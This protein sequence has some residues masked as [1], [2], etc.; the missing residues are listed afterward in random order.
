MARPEVHALALACLKQDT[1]MLAALLSA[2]EAVDQRLCSPG[3]QSVGGD[4]RVQRR[5]E[6]RLYP[7]WTA[8]LMCCHWGY[9]DC[10]R[11]LLRFNANVEIALPDARGT[12]DTAPLHH[13][14]LENNVEC[15]TL[16]LDAGARINRGNVHNST[17]LFLA[18]GLNNIECVRLLLHRDADV[19]QKRN[20]STT[21]LAFAIHF[22]NLDV[23]KLLVA[24]GAPLM[25][26][27]QEKGALSY[28]L[29]RLM[30]GQPGS[31]AVQS[32]LQDLNARLPPEV[33]WK[34][35][36]PL[37]FAHELDSLG[38]PLLTAE[39]VHR[40]L[41]SGAWKVPL[42][43]NELSV[44]PSASTSDHALL[45]A[46]AAD[47]W[48]TANHEL[49]PARAR[50][51]AHVLLVLGASLPRQLPVRPAD[52]QRSQQAFLDVWIDCVMPLLV[53][54]TSETP[55]HRCL[56][57]HRTAAEA[58]KAKLLRCTGCVIPE[59]R[60]C[61]AACQRAAWPVHRVACKANPRA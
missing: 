33:G 11:V 17:P 16:L 6:G 47:P 13:A 7:D 38:A 29:I 8:L 51:Y 9:A 60:F 54:R 35:L 58:G 40:F 61:G 56:H 55:A 37:Y 4:G 23:V 30:K 42:G 18:A 53:T 1:V 27:F 44:P 24:H 52:A 2:G 59:A 39:R 50:A 15:A 34:P 26:V 31:T 49:F 48:S 14:V 43:E 41:R 22:G 25:P 32:W 36:N 19:L 3:L 57:C 12:S 46:R 5:E 20:D 45:L 10:V 28:A 21:P